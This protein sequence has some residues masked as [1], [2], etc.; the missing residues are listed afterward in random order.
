M[1]GLRKEVQP[2]M[3]AR[4]AR[5]HITEMDT[6]FVLVHAIIDSFHEFFDGIPGVR[7]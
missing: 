6:R 1:G 7:T 2:V 5:T 4:S 3:S